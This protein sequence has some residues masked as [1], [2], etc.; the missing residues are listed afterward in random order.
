MHPSTMS[1]IADRAVLDSPLFK[2]PPEL[3]DTIWEYAVGSDPKTTLGKDDSCVPAIKLFV[4]YN[5]EEPTLLHVCRTIRREAL[6]FFLARPPYKVDLRV[7]RLRKIRLSLDFWEHEASSIFSESNSEREKVT[8]TL[9][10]PHDTAWADVTRWLREAEEVLNRLGDD[11]RVARRIMSLCAVYDPVLMS[12]VCA[13][14]PVE[15]RK[16]IDFGPVS[17]FPFHF[18]CGAVVTT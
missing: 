11:T 7:R 6:G 12:V 1:T 10:Y 5:V 17:L 18:Q 2:L 15:R 8:S 3:R 4:L 14:I 9:H 16:T 13:I